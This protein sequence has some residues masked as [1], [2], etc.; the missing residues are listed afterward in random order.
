MSEQYD[1][2]VRYD[3]MAHTGEKVAEVV[4]GVA[5]EGA[6]DFQQ[7]IGELSQLGR[8]EGST[9][10]REDGAVFNLVPQR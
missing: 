6:P 2:K 3:L 8:V 10:I 5:Y 4:K 1:P 9:L 7:K